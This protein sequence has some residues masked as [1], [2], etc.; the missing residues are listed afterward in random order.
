MTDTPASFRKRR[1]LTQQQLATQLGIH[2][3]TISK[4]ERKNQPVRPSWLAL[5]EL[6]RLGYRTEE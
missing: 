4:W 1:G 2:I 5:K 6:M 3:S